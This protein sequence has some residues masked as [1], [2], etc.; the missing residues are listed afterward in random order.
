MR[1]S[2]KRTLAILKRGRGEDRV[3]A[4]PAVSC[5]MMHKQMRTR[6]YRFSGNTPAFP[7]QWLY[8]LYVLSPVTGWFVTVDRRKR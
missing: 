8:G 6:A 3:R 7:A 1:S 4:A 2:K 5:A